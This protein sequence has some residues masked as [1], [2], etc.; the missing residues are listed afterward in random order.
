MAVVIHTIQIRSVIY[1][2]MD[3]TMMDMKGLNRWG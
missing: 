2:P 1:G 3:T